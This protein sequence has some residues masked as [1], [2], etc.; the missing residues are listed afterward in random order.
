[1]E[2]GLSDEALDPQLSFLDDYDEIVEIELDDFCGE[3]KLKR[4]VPARYV[5]DED[6]PV[7]VTTVFDLTMA[8]FGVAARPA[9]DYPADYDQDL[10]YT[11]AWQEK[12][13]G[14]HRD[15]LVRFAREWATNGEKTNGKNLVIIG[16]GVNHWYHNNLLYR[17]AIVALMLTGSVGINGGGLAH[18]VGQEKVVNQASWGAIALVWI[19]VWRLVT[20]TRPHS[21][22]CIPTNGATSAVS[23]PMIACLAN[24]AR[25]T[26]ST[27]RRGRCG[28]VGYPFTRNS[29]AA[30]WNWRAKLKLRAPRMNRRSSITWSTNW[31]VGSCTSR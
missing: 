16:A 19:G 10:P 24:S 13:T 30:R 5:Q 9:G 17:S 26:R 28:A 12:Y 31:Q 3:V 7:L 4:G 22:T 11:P 27:T 14:I 25:N 18:Y 6:G 23:R 15:T 29:T 2:E 1:M 20:R 8:Q 21:I